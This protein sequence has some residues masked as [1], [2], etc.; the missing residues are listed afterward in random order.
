[1]HSKKTEIEERIILKVKEL[2]IARNIS[3]LELSSIL[4]IS[5]GLVG[6]I[7][8]PRF[9]HKY[10]LKQL[11]QFCTAIDFPF[12]KLFLTDEELTS[13]NSIKVLIEKII[14]YDE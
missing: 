7:E 6:N 13:D 1:M 3:Q 9:Q 12:E 4:G 10:T 5:S 11:H 8:S 2:R 14:Q